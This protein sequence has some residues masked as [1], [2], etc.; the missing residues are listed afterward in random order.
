MNTI[1]LANELAESV[2]GKRHYGQVLNSLSI[3]KKL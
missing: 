2:W 3:H 1:K